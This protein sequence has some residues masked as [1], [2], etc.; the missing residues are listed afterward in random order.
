MRPPLSRRQQWAARYQISTIGIGMPNNHASPYFMTSPR[1]AT[2]ADALSIRDAGL[3]GV[4]RCESRRVPREPR[5]RCLRLSSTKEKP[6][7]EAAEVVI[8]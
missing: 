8:V 4:V 2:A 6:S 5:Q 1:W 3:K 7:L